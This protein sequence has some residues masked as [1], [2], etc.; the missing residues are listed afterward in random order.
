MSDEA[1]DERNLEAIQRNSLYSRDVDAGEKIGIIVGTIAKELDD[2]GEKIN[3]A[4]TPMVKRV[5]RRYLQSCQRTGAIPT[6]FGFTR[7]CGL[8]KHAC[9]RFMHRQPQHDTTAFL[10]VAFDAFADANV[11][12]GQT[13]SCH[14]IFAMFILKALYHVR[15]NDP[16]QQP[17]DN[18]IG[19][20][21]D[22]ET[23]MKK[24]EDI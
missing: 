13:G 4:D 2:V 21:T 1:M 17:A 15:E 14:P 6:I 3:L 23:L 8:S 5:M 12:A 10:E 18:P 7:A 19:E 11:Q 20:A 16:I 9:D 22:T 24:Y